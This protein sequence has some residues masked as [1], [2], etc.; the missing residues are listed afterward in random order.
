MTPKVRTS[1]E[2]EHHEMLLEHGTRPG[3]RCA[4][5]TFLGDDSGAGGTGTYCRMAPTIGAA[6]VAW[7]ESWVACGEHAA[8]GGG[9]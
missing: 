3:R 2:V 9:D 6:G 1:P 8:L 4:S 5:C 7:S